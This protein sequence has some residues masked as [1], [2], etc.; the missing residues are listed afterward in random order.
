MMIK[1]DAILIIRLSALGDVAMTI[2][3]IYSFAGQYPE[4]K[5]KV[6]TR[7]SFT[8]LFI[9]CPPNVTLIT[10]D[11][12]GAHR[13][14]IGFCRLMKQICAERIG[15]VADF[16]N[17]S[18]SWSIDACFM[19][20]GKSVA[21]VH[22]GRM[23]RKQLTRKKNKNRATQLNYTE[24]YFNV[25][26]ALNLPTEPT[27]VSL[28]Q[29]EEDNNA[30]PSFI[31]PKGDSK[32]IGIAPFARYQTKIYPLP[33]MEKVIEQLSGESYTLFLFG[34][35]AY[36][37]EV[38]K[39]WEK[40]YDSVQALP[41]LLDFTQELSL[42]NRLDLMISMDSANMHLASLVGTPVLSIWGGTTPHCGFLGW[43]QKEENAIY[44]RIDCQPCS[45]SGT[46]KCYLNSY[47]CMNN[48]P[49][50]VIVEHAKRILL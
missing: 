26:S 2:P 38:L 27:F 18:R 46:E 6:L 33:L 12:K 41:G 48:I 15:A 9:N 34:G 20:L 16:H 3:V 10:A 1:N 14:F 36:E 24:R 47:Q 5:I 28:F 30:L 45:I 23:A 32:W 25:L 49:P 22:K 19:L 39:S 17:V 4:Q 35:G 21:I 37:Q 43:K 40:Q 8:K 29:K 31:P 13:G 42:M 11:F 7:A 50:Q 44:A